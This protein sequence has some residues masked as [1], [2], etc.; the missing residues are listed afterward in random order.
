MI[1]LVCFIH[2]VDKLPLFQAAMPYGCKTVIPAMETILAD[3]LFLIFRSVDIGI[4]DPLCLGRSHHEFLALDD[5]FFLKLIAEPLID[6]V[7]CLCTL[8]NI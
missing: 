1:L 2:T 4:I 5:I 7:L 3:D 8:D 6:L